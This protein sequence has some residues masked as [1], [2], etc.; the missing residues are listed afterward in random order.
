MTGGQ[1]AQGALPIP[2]LTKKLEAE[3]VRKI[4][5]LAE[6]VDRFDDVELASVAEVRDRSALEQTLTDMAKLKGVTAMIYDQECAAEKR[7]K[8]SRGTYAE[9]VTRLMINDEVCEGCGDCVKQ[10]NCMSLI[11]FATDRGQ[12]MRIHQSSCNKDYSCALGDCPSFVTVKIKEG[13]GLRRPS[14]PQLPPAEVPAPREIADISRDGYRMVFPGIGGTGVVTI[15]ALLATAAWIDGLHVATLD[16]TGSAQKGGAVVS[17]LLI[18]KQPVEAP[19]RTNIGNADLVLGFDVIGVANPEHLKF[20]S[21]D[22]TTAVLN[23]N[24]TPTIDVIR[25]RNIL[26]GP[27]MMIEKINSVTRRGRNVIVDANRIAESLFGSH[28]AVNLFMVGLAY[29]GGL[30]PLSLAAIEQAITWN[31][32]DVEKNL[33]VFEWGRKYYHDA[34]SVEQ[35]LK[36]KQSSDARAFDRAAELRAYQSDAYAREYTE[37]VARVAA[38]APALEETVARYLYKLMSYKDEYEVARLLTKP[39]FA[40][41]IDETWQQVES[42]SYN[43]HPPLLRR[44]GVK[45]K[46]KLGAW[47]RGPLKMLAA[48]KGLRGSAFDVFGWSPHRRM[49]RELIGWYR[50]LIEQVLDRVTEENLPKALE[51]AALPDQIR[52]YE[53]IKE[54]NVARA[55]KCAEEKLAELNKVPALV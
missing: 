38:K 5:I 42:I 28:L 47:F 7:R 1:A 11:P 18:S 9:P 14:I 50:G 26:A 25:G 51:I 33:Q 52:G 21:P 27:E 48:M 32:V 19:V 24:L 3:G 17:H 23:T 22:R 41:K 44:F 34:A 8:R 6:D 49:E 54:E 37:F 29:Q 16:Q 13:T 46:M 40:Q 35:F 4:I 36:P 2:Q 31:G 39:E 10:S 20:F 55:K 12:K 30:I 53:H 15:N 45:R 43:L